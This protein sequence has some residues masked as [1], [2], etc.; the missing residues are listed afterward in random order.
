[1]ILREL[2]GSRIQRI[3]TRLSDGW[4]TPRRIAATAVLYTVRRVRQIE[5]KRLALNVRFVRFSAATYGQVKP[6]HKT[7]ETRH[8]FRAILCTKSHRDPVKCVP[9]AF[10]AEYLAS[11]VYLCKY[12]RG[13]PSAGPFNPKSFVGNGDAGTTCCVSTTNAHCINYARTE[14]RR[15]AVY[16]LHIVVRLLHKN[17][18]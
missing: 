1:M 15:N 11:S 5:N 4:P 7:A 14:T 12:K 2:H 3:P 6:G 10:I 9:S 16:V 17:R 13:S 8:R 18:W